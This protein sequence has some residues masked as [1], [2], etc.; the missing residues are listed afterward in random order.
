MKLPFNSKSSSRFQ[1]GRPR[2]FILIES[3]VVGLLIVVLSPLFGRIV[4]LRSPQM[5]V[6]SLL[7]QEVARGTGTR[8]TVDVL[9]P[10]QLESSLVT[11]NEL[12]LARQWGEAVTASG[13]KESHG[14]VWWLDQW[15]NTARPFSFR[16][17]G[18]DSA[19]FLEQWQFHVSRKL[20]C[21]ST[22]IVA[23]FKNV[24]PG[25]TLWTLALDEEK[26]TLRAFPH[27][28]WKVRG[29]FHR[30]HSACCG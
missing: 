5:I 2:G 10:H 21:N 1:Y 7:A 29:T 14:D 23:Q 27:P 15:L 17:G 9:L 11:H 19:S 3:R 24:T 13:P 18:K 26:Q 6:S 20:K 8:Q 16:Y 25:D 4:T 22:T 12:Q 28:A 30:F